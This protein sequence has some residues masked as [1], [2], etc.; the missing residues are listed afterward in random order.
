MPRDRLEQLKA[1]D[2]AVLTEVVRRDQCSSDFVIINWTVE[3]LS[4]KGIANPDAL[5]R[6]YGRG[7]LGVVER[8]WSVVLKILTAPADQTSASGV[9]YW[10]R[11][12]LL[13]QS[14]LLA[15]LP[16]PVSAP[17][18]YRVSEEDGLGW[19]W[20]EHI[21]ATSG[22]PWTQN[23]YAF[24]ARQLGQ[25]NGTYLGGTPLPDAPWLSKD[26]YR[27]W[28][29]GYERGVEAG[30]GNPLFRRRLSSAAQSR[31]LALSADRERFF[32]ALDGLP[33]VF[34]H[35]DFGRRNLFVRQG[36]NYRPELVVID[37]ALCGNGP[38]GGDLCALV[39]MSALH[40]EYDP[41]TAPQ[42]AA[43]AVEAYLAG[44][45]DAGW[46][47]APDLV[48][49]GYTAGLAMHLGVS[50]PMVVPWFVIEESRPFAMQQFGVAG[51]ELLERW[52]PLFLYI[53]D[54]ADEARRLMARLDL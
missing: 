4:N 42:M 43:T 22:Q 34:C 36:L 38:M 44:L 32:S 10:K 1:I 48:R 17:R 49:L 33:Q 41:A 28:V 46:T 54:C 27:G 45:R 7:R 21:Q 50:F 53:L 5:F 39:G 29:A 40:L 47:G 6:F 12:L 23:E 35:F 26:H 37:W 14:A 25:W 51:E 2:S 8:P 52:V 3:R 19:I 18:F 30:W 11:E 9:G 15:N 24:A 31:Y 13:A 16:G 20:M